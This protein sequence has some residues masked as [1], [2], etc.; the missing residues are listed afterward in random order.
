MKTRKIFSKVMVGAMLFSAVA[1][2]MVNTVTAL[3]DTVS[4]QG[5]LT[6][7]T[8]NQTIPL[9]KEQVL[10]ANEWDNEYSSGN[11]YNTSG[12]NIRDV[13]SYRDISTVRMTG[14][15][16]FNVSYNDVNNVSEEDEIIFNRRQN[17]A[18]S[19]KLFFPDGF[20]YNEGSFTLDDNTPDVESIVY[21]RSE[22]SI[23][24]NNL[25][26]KTKEGFQNWE[27]QLTKDNNLPLETYGIVESAVNFN[28][29]DNGKQ[30]DSVGSYGY[31]EADYSYLDIM[32]TG[33]LYILDIVDYNFTYDYFTDKTE[34]NVGDTV[35]LNVNIYDSTDYSN[36]Y[37]SNTNLELA[38]LPD[39]TLYIPEGMEVISVDGLDN[40]NLVQTTE[41]TYKI[42]QDYD[43]QNNFKTGDVKSYIFN[44]LVTEYVNEYVDLNTDLLINSIVKNRIESHINVTDLNYDNYRNQYLSTPIKINKD[45]EIIEN[46]IGQLTVN[47]LD[48]DGNQLIESANYMYIFG[49]SYGVI[50]ETIKGYNLIGEEFVTGII[51]QE[52]TIV[53]FIYKKDDNPVE[54]KGKIITKYVDENGKDLIEPK[55]FLDVVGKD[56]SVNAETIEGYELT[57]D[58]KVTGKVTK[59]DT[60]ITFTYEKVKEPEEPEVPVEPTE[61][62]TPEKPVEPTEP[63]TS[64][65]STDTEK[66]PTKEEDKKDNLYQTNY[67]SNNY[68]LALITTALAS[69]IAFITFK[70]FKK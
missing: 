70:K 29:V 21:D 56:F 63:T 16:L 46:N 1:L 8:Y 38:Y 12:F 30:F 59:E 14:N 4:N 39:F 68:L 27:I 13:E 65:T 5:Y 49:E 64:T 66:E 9:T 37:I 18:V 55:E 43:S 24:I 3:A 53:N 48:E 28:Y 45:D 31:F 10:I 32:N 57:S 7:K 42:V 17:V 61:P 15:V 54:E 26:I 20:T 34:Y 35:A 2:P 50:A 25:R 11:V 67:S 60:V 69:V 23:T 44:L 52:E 22:N 47:Y 40:A 19:F 41:S 58:S 6:N 36:Q 62:T 51:N 33:R